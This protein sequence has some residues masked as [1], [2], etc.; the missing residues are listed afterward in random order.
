MR[1]LCLVAVVCYPIAVWFWPLFS[2][3]DAQPDRF[4]IGRFVLLPACA[5][6]SPSRCAGR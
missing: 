5:R 4:W 1:P 3:T 6:W 2:T